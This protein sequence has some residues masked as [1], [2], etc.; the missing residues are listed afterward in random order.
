LSSAQS[1]WSVWLAGSLAPHAALL[2]TLAEIGP[3]VAALRAQFA[4]AA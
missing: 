4:S 2:S 3:P 1:R